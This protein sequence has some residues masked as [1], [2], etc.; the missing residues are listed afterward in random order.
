MFFIFTETPISQNVLRSLPCGARV[1]YFMDKVTEK[2]STLT[3]MLD[4]SDGKIKFWYR[5]N[6]LLTKC[7]IVIYQNKKVIAEKI[8]WAN[9][10]LIGTKKKELSMGNYSLQILNNG[11]ILEAKNFEISGVK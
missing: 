9:A 3:Q 10:E 11:E 7:K 1:E 2:K 6:W 8:F 5:N 4:T